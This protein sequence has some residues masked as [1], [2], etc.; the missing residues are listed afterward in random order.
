MADTKYINNVV[1]D[2]EAKLDL[3]G[4][5]V[6][7][8]IEHLLVHEEELQQMHA[9]AQKLGRPQAAEVIAKEAVALTKQ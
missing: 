4:D 6:L 1:L 8:F 9:A 5:T 2:G 3:T 7:E